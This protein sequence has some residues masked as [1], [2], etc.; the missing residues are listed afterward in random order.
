MSAYLQAAL[1]VEYLFNTAKTGMCVTQP[2]SALSIYLPPACLRSACPGFLLSHATTGFC[3]LPSTLITLLSWLFLIYPFSFRPPRLFLEPFLSFTKQNN[4]VAKSQRLHLKWEL[5][6]L[7]WTGLG[8][9]RRHVSLSSPT[10]R[11]RVCVCVCGGERE[12][13]QWVLQRKDLNFLEVLASSR[14]SAIEG[15]YR[16]T[17]YGCGKFSVFSFLKWKW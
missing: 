10:Y 16:M 15:P 11:T 1:T 17:G 5:P 8:P 14:H 6:A 9:G 13:V 7:L 12:T 2:R 3:I 4:K